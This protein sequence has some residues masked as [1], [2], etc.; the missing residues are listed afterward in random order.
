MLDVLDIPVKQVVIEARMVT[1]DDGVDEELGVRW[2]VTKAKEDG[3]ISGTI[4]GNNTAADGTAPKVDDRLNVNLPVA[5]AAG[6]IAFQVAKLA[7]GTLLDLE[8]SALE[9]ENKAEIIASPRV[10]T[11]NQKEAIIEQGTEFPSNSSSSSGAT[12]VEWKKAVLSLKVTPHITPDN[13]VILD[14]TVTQDTLGKEVKTGTG[15]GTAINTQQISTQVLVDNGET[16]V[17]GGIYQQTIKKDVTKVPLLGDIPGVGVLF[18][19]TSESNTKRELLI[20]VTPKIVV[21]SI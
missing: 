8:L 17:L 13:R 19:N 20:F 2:G 18:R 11:A 21:E 5:D 9:T 4:E 1:I 6:S 7:D 12:T 10:T 14:L 3:S 15:T 16:L